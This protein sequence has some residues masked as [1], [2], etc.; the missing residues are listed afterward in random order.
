MHAW[1][2][3]A[4]AVGHFSTLLDGKENEKKVAHAAENARSAGGNSRMDDPSMMDISP[5]HT[6]PCPAVEE[7]VEASARQCACMR[8]HGT[9]RIRVRARAAPEYDAPCRYFRCGAGSAAIARAPS[10]D[11]KMHLHRL[12]P[13]VHVCVTGLCKCRASVSHSVF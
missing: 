11:V 12:A 7:G 4:V 5:S 2:H 1:M 6:A 3:G 9:N 10:Y 8:G 13:P